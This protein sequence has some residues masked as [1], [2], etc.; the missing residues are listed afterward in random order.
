MFRLSFTFLAVLAAA[1][2]AHAE[3]TQT[4]TIT[5]QSDSRSARARAVDAAEKVCADARVHDP[6]DDYGTQEECVQNT[7]DRLYRTDASEGG[8]GR[9]TASK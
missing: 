1:S 3:D 2:V 4:N 8:L 9:Q 6:F 7:L 5:I